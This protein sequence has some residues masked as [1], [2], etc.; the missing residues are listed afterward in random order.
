[1]ML[2][3]PSLETAALWREREVLQ[4]EYSARARDGQTLCDAALAWALA[5]GHPLADFHAGHAAS[6][7]LESP[8]FLPALQR[9]H[10]GHYQPARMRLTLIAPH[11][12]DQQLDLARR[13]GE[14]LEAGRHLPEPVVPPMLPLR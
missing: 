9:F 3:H 4:A 12:L 14:P 7:R 11:S 2:A 8:A 1:D 10:R 5:A 13:Y 6:L